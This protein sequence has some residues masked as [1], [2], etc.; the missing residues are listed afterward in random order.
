MATK[1]KYMDFGEAIHRIR[2]KVGTKI[3]RKGWN[4]KGMYVIYQEGYP[5]GVEI[6]HNTSR[7]TGLP[8]GTV[9]R[10]EPY[11]MFMTAKGTFIPWLASQS[12]IL[13]DDWFVLP[14]KGD[15]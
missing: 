2:S 10:F 3:A 15:K 12:D 1:T 8:V 13:A 6:N 4:G 11:L 9:C 14:V 7:A 5:E